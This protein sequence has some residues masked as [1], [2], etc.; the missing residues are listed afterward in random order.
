M[1][2]AVAR[3][4]V[5]HPTCGWTEVATSTAL[6]LAKLHSLLGSEPHRNC[7]AFLRDR[8][9]RRGE[10]AVWR[11]TDAGKLVEAS[12]RALQLRLPCVITE[13]VNH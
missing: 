2:A 4:E 9:A 7:T 8:M 5:L 6:A 3:Y 1:S 11:Y 13:E 10:V 12:R